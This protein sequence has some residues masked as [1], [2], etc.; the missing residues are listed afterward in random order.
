MKINLQFSSSFVCNLERGVTESEV[1]SF[2]PKVLTKNP[3]TILESRWR[4][5]TF[6]SSGSSKNGADADTHFGWR[7][8]CK[9]SSRY[10]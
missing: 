1:F 8:K 9:S 3:I 6:L 4:V 5:G 2:R 10:F 7:M